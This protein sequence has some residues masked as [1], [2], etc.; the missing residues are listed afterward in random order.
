MIGFNILSLP[1]RKDRRERLR[2]NFLTQRIDLGDV[3]FHD[4]IHGADYPNSEAICQAAVADG[5]PEFEDWGLEPNDV[6]YHWGIMRILDYIISDDFTYELAVFSQDDI[7]LK[8]PYSQF[9]WV[10]EH[11]LRREKDEFLIWQPYWVLDK[12]IIELDYD[13]VFT[14]NSHTLRRGTFHSGDSLLV[15]SKKGAAL[16]RDTF[17]KQPLWFEQIPEKLNGYQGVY[18]SIDPFYFTYPMKSGSDREDSLLPVASQEAD[19]QSFIK[20]L[21]E[22]NSSKQHAHNYGFFYECLLRT[23]R[24]K[25]KR[26]IKVLEI[27]VVGIG[28]EKSSEYA[29]RTSADVDMYVG[30]DNCPL[31]T[32]FGKNSHFIETDAYTPD[33]LEYLKDFGKF[34]LIIDDGSH[35]FQDQ[36]KFFDIYRHVRSE[37]SVMVCEDVMAWSTPMVLDAIRELGFKNNYWVG[38]QLFTDKG[39]EASMLANLIVNY[40]YP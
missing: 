21:L 15:M 11:L 33:V 23:L 19:T 34:D 14:V 13:K 36:I 2:G 35:R 30:I 25:H 10:A 16:M 9:F 22:T 40:Q 37:V 5:Y 3:I 8:Q 26:P 38:T 39:L 6:A 28:S 24:V 1:F 32:E 31:N 29:F 17:R 20:L 12:P 27:G 4:A 7:F 18:A